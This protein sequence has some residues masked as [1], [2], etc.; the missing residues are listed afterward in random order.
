MHIIDPMQN[1]PDDSRHAPPG[2]ERLVGKLVVS[3]HRLTR[4]ASQALHD[5][6]N[7]AVW[8]TI[9]ALE[10]AGPIRLGELARRSRVTQPTMTK[11]VQH[12]E[13]LEWVRSIPDPADGRARL[14]DA[15]DAGAEAIDEW[16][17]LI[18]EAL[19]P[20]FEDLS[21]EDAETIRRTLEILDERTSADNDE[22][23]R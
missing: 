21:V 23:T 8:R 1:D 3:A 20:Y 5:P 22:S 9:A 12:L 10:E 16:R 11:I 14:L 2:A 18:T 15:T 19:A 7:A 4:L 6:Q 13:K 17:T